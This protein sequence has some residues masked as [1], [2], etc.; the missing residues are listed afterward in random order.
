MAEAAPSARAIYDAW[1]TDL[2]GQVHVASRGTYGA[3]RVQAELV[4]GR[5]VSI[6]HRAVEYHPS[7]SGA[8]GTDPGSLSQHNQLHRTQDGPELP[9]TQA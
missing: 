7:S 3:Q 4:L 1:L 5:S 2:I 9:S 8:T 6:G